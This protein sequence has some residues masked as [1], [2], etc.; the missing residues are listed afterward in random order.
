MSQRQPM[1]NLQ[2]RTAAAIVCVSM[3]S[4]TGAGTDW[5][6]TG[7]PMMECKTALSHEEVDGDM[8]KAIEWLRK[9]G[10]QTAAKKSGRETKVRA[11]VRV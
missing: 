4:G 3:R 8:D 9:N 2:I 11:C 5:Q 6:G 7:A 1:W 10:V